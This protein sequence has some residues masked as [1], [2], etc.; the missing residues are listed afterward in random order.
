MLH[1]LRIPL[2]GLLVGSTALACVYLIAI[3]TNQYRSIV[4]ALSV[5]TAIKMMS[6]PQASPFSYLAMAIQSLCCMPLAGPRGRSRIWVTAMFLLASMYSPLQK[7]V[8][9]YI[10]FGQQ[11]LSVVLGELRDW[12][13]PNLTTSEFLMFPLVLWFGSHLMAGF[14]LAKW[15]HRW[16]MPDGARLELHDEWKRT[17]TM[18]PPTQTPARIFG[19]RH[20]V[21]SSAAVAALSLLFVFETDL[22]GWFHVLWRPLLI[23]VC[24]QLM[25]RPLM[26]IL[27]RRWTAST[28]NESDI[29]AVMD[30]FPR[31]WSILSFAQKKSNEVTGWIGRIRTFLRVTMHVSLTS[32]PEV[33]HD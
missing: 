20:I 25:A 17:E 6:S 32:N 3:T 15:L 19:R 28:R 5:V 16:S 2:T 18:T 7:L 26:I 4:K 1:A 23:I 13:A 22:P 31:M 10:T 9:L 33:L 30:E 12:V 21:S 14:L 27:S 24:W 11:G 29:R 8:I